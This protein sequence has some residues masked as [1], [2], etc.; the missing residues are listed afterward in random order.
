MNRGSALRESRSCHF[1][2]KRLTVKHGGKGNFK[3]GRMNCRKAVLSKSILFTS[4]P[5]LKFDPG[6]ATAQPKA[7]P[8]CPSV[9]RELKN[10]LGEKGC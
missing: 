7:F 9:K 8:P 2:D 6:P 10:H 1:A 5:C 4:L 3:G